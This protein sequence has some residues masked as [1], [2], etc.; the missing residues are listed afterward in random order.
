MKGRQ[1]LQIPGPTNIPPR[2]LRSLSQPMINHRGSDF[3]Q[4]VEECVDNLKKVFRT[5]NDTLVFPSSG[6][7][8]LESVVV[9]LFSP[10]NKILAVSQGVFSERMATIA[11]KHNLQVRR[12]T[13]EWGFNIKAEEIQAVLEQ[14]KEKKIKAVCLPHNETSTAVSNDLKEITKAIKEIEHPALIVVDAISSLACLPLES[15]L[16]KIDVVVA[17]SQKG[18]M[19][20]PGLGFVSVSDRAWESIETSSMAKWYWE[21]RAVKDSLKHHIFP[22]TP[23]TTLFFGLKE[24]LCM[25][26]EEGIENVWERHAVMAEAVRNAAKGI[27]LTLFAKE[28]KAC[29]NTVTAILVPDQI[30]YTE[31]AEELKAKFNLEIG[32]GLQQLKGQI[33]RIG[34]LG[35]IH[36]LEIY[37]IMGAVEMIL[38]QMGFPVKLGSAAEAVAKTF[39]RH[40]IPHRNQ[41]C[42]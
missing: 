8:M 29:S 4:I 3:Q 42:Y 11:E 26:A 28:E 30:S 17:S 25:L 12:L 31:L 19:L 14:D 35:S 33:F 20:P 34:H 37:A 21:Y 27:N 40:S 6:S 2:I 36:H 1:F 24:S 7:G 38:S 9:N 32:G 41:V 22:Y 15:D 5:N 13:K 18:L 10:G 16:W 39:L 23:A